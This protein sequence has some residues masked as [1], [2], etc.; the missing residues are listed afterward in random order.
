MRKKSWPPFQLKCPY[1]DCSTSTTSPASGQVVRSGSYWRKDDSQRIPRFFCHTCLRTF[2]SSRRTSCFKQKR[3]TLNRK[4]KQLLCSGISQRRIALL[5][6]IDRKTVV[7]KL[8]FLA[9]EARLERM[10]F[11]ALLEKTKIEK[12]QFDEMESFE[13]SKCLPVSIPLVV[14]PKDRKVLSF[15]VGKM[16]A[17]GLLAA[18]SRRK[19]GP[20]EDERSVKAHEVFS[21]IASTVRPDVEITTDKNPKYPVWIASHF[22]KSKHLTVKGKR[23]CIVGQGELKKTGFDPLFDLNHSA[24]MLRANI[25]RLFRRTWCTTKRPDRLEA[26]IELYVQFHNTVLT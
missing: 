13:R 9:N 7:R 24:A 22:P 2:S 4:I 16:P 26:H 10:V 17:K 12:I 6:G 1:S 21:E 15:R 20:R 3:R 23:G 11:L 19:Y 8:L 5:L 18:T 25:N 14:L